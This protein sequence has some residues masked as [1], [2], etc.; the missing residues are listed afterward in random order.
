MPKQLIL[1]RKDGSCSLVPH[2]LLNELDIPFSSAVLKFENGQMSAADGSFTNAEYKKVHPRGF[3][4]ALNVDGE[5][6]T[7][8]PAI[9]TYISELAP[10]R[11]SLGST[12]SERAKAYEWMTWLSGTLH[13][14]GYGALWRPMRFTDDDSEGVHSAITE[15]GF[16]TIVYC[17][18][19]IEDSLEGPHAV[20]DRFTAVDL[21]LYNFWRWGALRVG[22]QP[23][24]MREKYPRFAKLAKA[25]EEMQSVRKT[26][27]VENLQR[28]FP[29]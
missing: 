26:L 2:A 9:L 14:T 17:H 18:E 21:N 24:E 5:I 27:K 11:N 1:Y 3:V 16:R 8:M 7:E 4:P 22:L 23:N 13:G 25:V 15:K 10:N 29:G 28:A 12:P 20:G 6:I 19:R